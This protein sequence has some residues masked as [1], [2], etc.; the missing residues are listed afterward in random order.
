MGLREQGPQPI[1]HKQDNGFLSAQQPVNNQD[2]PTAQTIYIQTRV[3]MSIAVRQPGTGNNA[4]MEAGRHKGQTQVTTGPSQQAIN[5]ARH[6]G[7]ARPLLPGLIKQHPVQQ[8]RQQP[9]QINRAG[10]WTTNMIHG[11]E[12]T[13]IHKTITRTVNNISIQ[14][15]AAI[16]P[17]ARLHR[18]AAVLPEK[19]VN[20]HRLTGNQAQ[21]P[22]EGNYILY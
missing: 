17:G 15:L 11:A 14:A 10:A 21:I 9:I 5:K 12:V 20:L 2:R 16:H 8:H 19:A 7:T 4:A 18:A 3:E 13:S 1:T 22:E 6:Q